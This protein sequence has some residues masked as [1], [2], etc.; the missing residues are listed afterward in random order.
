MFKTN[1]SGP[2]NRDKAV[3]CA[4]HLLHSHVRR[5]TDDPVA[6]QLDH[7]HQADD[8][9]SPLGFCVIAHGMLRVHIESHLEGMNAFERM[10]D[11]VRPHVILNERLEV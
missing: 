2:I 8:H 5:Q 4:I 3:C 10:Q 11:L 7:T 6:E 9:D 1:D